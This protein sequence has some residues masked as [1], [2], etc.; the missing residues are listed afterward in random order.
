MGAV[1]VGVRQTDARTEDG[2]VQGVPSGSGNLHP[3]V[4][5]HAQPSR[6]LR[7]HPRHSLITLQYRPTA[8][9]MTPPKQAR[10][11]RPTLHRKCNKHQKNGTSLRLHGH[12]KLDITGRKRKRHPGGRARG[13]PGTKHPTQ[14][15]THH[16]PNNKP[17]TYDTKSTHKHKAYRYQWCLAHMTASSVCTVLPTFRW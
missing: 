14:P 6:F 4:T 12:G 5:G 8:S 13:P 15:R 7:D 2:E 1:Q 16:T 3:R 9:A 11:C 10:H 17:H